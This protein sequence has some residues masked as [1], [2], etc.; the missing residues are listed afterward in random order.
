MK[1]FLPQFFIILLQDGSGTKMFFDGEGNGN[2]L[3]Y[4]CWKNP[5]TEESGGL[6]SMGLHDW[7]CVHE[8]GGRWVGSNKLVELKKKK[9]VLWTGFYLILW[10]LVLQ[11][12]SSFWCIIFLSWE[13]MQMCSAPRWLSGHKK[14]WLPPAC[15]IQHHSSRIFWR[16][17]TIR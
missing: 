2:P 7:A 1:I 17:F 6:K 8:G 15:Y 11:V 16:S 3:Q 13:V 5:R 4:S 14:L 9:N 10:A 12:F